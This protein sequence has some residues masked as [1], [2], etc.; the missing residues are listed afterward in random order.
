MKHYQTKDL[1]LRVKDMDM[2]DGRVQMYVSAFDSVDSDNDVMMRGCFAK[3][4]AE[5]GPSGKNRIKQLWMHSPWDL[6]GRPEN[7][8]EDGTGL[9]VDGFVSDVKNGD[10]RKMYQDGLITEH[11]IGFMPIKYEVVTRENDRQGYDFKEVA[12]MEYSAVVWG[13]NENT[14]VLGMKALNA[15]EQIGEIRGQLDRINKALR[16]GT[17]TDETMLQLQLAHK[18]LEASIFKALEAKNQ[19]PQGTGASDEPLDLV[20]LFNNA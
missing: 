1:A 2:A 12:L 19:P 7:I 14:P 13:A 17:Y 4:I 8:V 9:L 5:N 20:Q 16:N 11:S 3:T 6:I 10:Y 15:P 18:Q